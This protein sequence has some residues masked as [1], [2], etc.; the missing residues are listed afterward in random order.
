MPAS[1]LTIVDAR[2]VSVLEA[3]GGCVF[4][5]HGGGHNDIDGIEGLYNAT[6]KAGR[7][8]DLRLIVKSDDDDFGVFG[9]ITGDGDKS[10]T[11]HLPG[12]IV[13]YISVKAANEIKLIKLTTPGTM[14]SWS[15]LNIRNRGGNQPD[16]SHISFFG[17]VIPEP[18]TWA[19]MIAGF[20][21]VGGAMRRRR[22]SM[23]H[24]TA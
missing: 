2:C 10:G 5:V 1:A 23:A 17:A 16:M 24:E 7:N 19:M 14:G 6:T 12:H 21:L 15:T 9:S 3:D 8:I 20:G 11:W 13:D 22:T 18:A 4:N